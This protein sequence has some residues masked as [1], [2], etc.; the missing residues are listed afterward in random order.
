MKLL[1]KL[2]CKFYGHRRGKRI[3]NVTVKCPRCGAERDRLA[4]KPKAPNARI[5]T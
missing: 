3:S 2:L 5:A 1:G 4:R